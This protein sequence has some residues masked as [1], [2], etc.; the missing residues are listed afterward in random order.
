[1]GGQEVWWLMKIC[2]VIEPIDSA[3]ALFELSIY[4]AHELIKVDVRVCV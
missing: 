4:P 2:I 3:A 1:M